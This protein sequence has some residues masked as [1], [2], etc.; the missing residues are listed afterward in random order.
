MEDLGRKRINSSAS[1][2]RICWCPTKIGL[3]ENRLPPNHRPSQVYL[4]PTLSLSSAPSD[5]PS[6][7]PSQ[8]PSYIP[9]IAPSSKPSST[10]SAQP[11]KVPSTTPS[12]T[13]LKIIRN[14]PDTPATL[15]TT[16]DR[17]HR[18]HLLTYQHE[19]SNKPRQFPSNW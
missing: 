9:S 8:I 13:I 4:L 6:L 18:S 14:T 11:S 16:F 15:P 5:I 2:D 1:S 17:H 12:T 3:G 10:P 7:S 19:P